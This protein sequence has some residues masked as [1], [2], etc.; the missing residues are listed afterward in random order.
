MTCVHHSLLELSLTATE[1]LNLTP[2][3]CSWTV[4]LPWVSRQQDSCVGVVLW[5]Q[6]WPNRLLGAP[7]HSCFSCPA[8]LTF[9]PLSEV[10]D[11][12][13]VS[14]TLPGS[15]PFPSK[16]PVSQTGIGCFCLLP[17]QGQVRRWEQTTGILGSCQ[18][19]GQLRGHAWAEAGVQ[20]GSSVTRP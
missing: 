20:D 10:C 16:S 9:R 1:P 5:D 3:C 19:N 12:G 6:V 4:W 2:P 7:P 18:Y 11:R 13:W 14:T 15:F 17:T 8:P